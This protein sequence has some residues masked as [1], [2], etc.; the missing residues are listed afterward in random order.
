MIRPCTAEDFEDIWQIVND[1]AAA[2]KG[3][4]P[5]DRSSDPYMT[6][7]ELRHETEQGIAF[8][9]IEEDATL[10]AVM[11]LQHVLDVT[12]IRHAYTRTH[13]Q[14]R[15]FGATL[16]SNLR[17]MTDRPVLI[18]TWA[19]AAWAI[20]FY[21]KHGFELV[22]PETKN[23]LLREYWS[24][25]DRQVETSVVLADGKWRALHPEQ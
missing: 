17:E 5:E 8:W 10:L 14:K 23:R 25:P 4:I 15:G 22:S 2:Y 1:G 7:K 19:D 9:G 13:A 24:I 21:R 18:G 16:L 6:R 11:G 20:R 3:M 12:L